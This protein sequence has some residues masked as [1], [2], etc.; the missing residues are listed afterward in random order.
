MA[1]PLLLQAFR[2]PDTLVLFSL[3]DWDLLLRQARCSNLLASLYAL[4]EER[5]LLG[6][7][8][9]QPRVHLEWAHIVA[10]KHLQAVHWEVTWIQKALAKMDIPVVLLKGAAYALAK[11]PSARGRLFSDIDILVPKEGLS[12][13]EAALMLH[14]WVATHHD[15][16]D[17]RYYRLWMHELPPMQHIRRMT[18]IDVHHGIVPE[19]AAIH[20]NPE[21]LLAASQWLDEERH[22]K[23]LAPADMVLHSAVHLFHGGEWENGLRDLVD[24][25]RLLVHFGTASSFW[26]ELVERAT[27]LEL[28]RPLF[29]AFRY[30]ARLLHT[31]VPAQVLSAAQAGCP[32]RLLLRV[33]DG[34]FIRALMP[35]HSSCADWLTGLARQMLYLRANWL[36]MPPWLLI[37]HLFHKAFISPRKK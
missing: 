35:P 29:Y 11:L 5:H 8:P 17:Q 20:P 10:L 32:P 2:Q 23:V 31:S 25:H 4:L 16:Y 33:M 7:V 14:G 3:M 37:R 12:A 27:E 1:R 26:G 9:P 15:A 21:K 6:I 22:V 13:V 28:I 34:L 24:I 30:T 19:T 18:V 36:R